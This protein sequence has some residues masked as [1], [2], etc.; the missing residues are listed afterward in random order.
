MQSWNLGNP[1]E[2][3]KDALTE[4]LRPSYYGVIPHWI[5]H[6]TT[7][8]KAKLIE[9]A[10]QKGTEEYE[11]AVIRTYQTLDR[12]ISERGDFKK[13]RLNAFV[14]LKL[15][16]N[17]ENMMRSQS[18]KELNSWKGS[19]ERTEDDKAHL[20]HI[21]RELHSRYNKVAG[22]RR[23]ARSM[24]NVNQR[25]YDDALGIMNQGKPEYE[26]EMTMTGQRFLQQQQQNYANMRPATVAGPVDRSKRNQSNV[27]FPGGSNWETT[28]NLFFIPLEDKT[29]VWN[30]ATLV[31]PQGTTM[32]PRT[33]RT[34]RGNP[35]APKD[36]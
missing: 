5:A 35:N 2:S 30:P 7:K 34:L 9:I 1:E 17:G 3:C 25:L 6:A 18:L 12:I 23:R 15:G 36:W 21:L 13:P 20:T 32:T 24:V 4:I 11:R 27:Y 14:K 19:L 26:Y 22:E 33:Y 31:S 29:R 28:H 8:E 16:K 10:G